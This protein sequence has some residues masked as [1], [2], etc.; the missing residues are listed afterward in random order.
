M[1]AD[2]ATYQKDGASVPRLRTDLELASGEVER[3]YAEPSVAAYRPE[4]V[5]AQLKHD[6]ISFDSLS[7]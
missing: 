3:L 1:L 5:L 7:F 2:P 4:A 6:E